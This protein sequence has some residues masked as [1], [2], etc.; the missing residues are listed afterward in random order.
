MIWTEIVFNIA[1][2]GYR[3]IHTA[4]EENGVNEI[5]SYPALSQSCE[6]FGR[7][8]LD[9][10]RYQTVRVRSP[11]DNAWRMPVL[12]SNACLGVRSL[13]IVGWARSAIVTEDAVGQRNWGKDAAA[14]ETHLLL[15]QR[16]REITYR[17]W[18]SI[19]FIRA[20]KFFIFYKFRNHN[21]CVGVDEGQTF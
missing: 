8:D 4:S 1:C 9:I 16:I 18:Q 14:L 19:F 6:N 12:E 11:D 10:I 21:T 20:R 13:G 3:R 2:S 17:C 7:M 5:T 15:P